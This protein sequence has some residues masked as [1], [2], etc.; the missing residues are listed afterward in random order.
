[1]VEIWVPYGP[2]EVYFDI[3][4]EN[5]SQVLEPQP[6]ALEKEGI[7]SRLDSVSADT[8]LLLS[9][10]AGCVKTLDTLLTRNK[11]VRKLLYPKNLGTLARRKAQEFAI[12]SDQ[13]NEQ[14]LEQSGVVD[15]SPVSVPLQVKS[16]QRLVLLT[17]I[18]YDPMY[19]LTSAASDLLSCA[20]TLKAEAF[21][22]CIDDLP[23][24]S[25]FSSAASD[26][27]IRVMQTCQSAD[28]I[29]IVE[30]ASGSV[31][32][33]F[34][35][36]IESVHSQ[37][38]S[39][40]TG[41]LGVRHSSRAERIVFGCGGQEGDRTLSK[42]LSRSFFN[43]ITNLALDDSRICI[44][45]EC[46]QGLGSEALLRYATGRFVPGSK[47]DAIDYFDGVEI[48][49]SLLK[50]QR[51]HNLNVNLVSTLPR[52]FVERFGFKP[53]SAASDAPSSVVQIGSRAK[54]LVV[55]DGSS[56]AF[57]VGETPQ[58]TAQATSVAVKSPPSSQ[59]PAPSSP[60][61]E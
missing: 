27:A 38:I 33:L 26:Y 5:L 18:H 36:D 3:K 20:G 11:G 51:D 61:A 6:L 40:W 56:I 22:R 17:S 23:C 31:L 34:Y 29:E 24:K 14:A 4:Q 53:L 12:E 41:N 13:L 37:I 35:G 15:G 58:E 59:P 54:I 7:E 19:G 8:L 57:G 21:N 16:S 10:S 30:R 43:V 25:Q 28:T 48:L 47:L 50:I 60:A 42:A 2:V 46:T 52:Y 44:L 32:N 45:A 39:Y 49:L 9:G 55:P 1:M